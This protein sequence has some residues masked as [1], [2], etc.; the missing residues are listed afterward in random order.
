[1]RPQLA[2]ALLLGGAFAF[3][4]TRA[5]IG[6]PDAFWHIAA[7]RDMLARGVLRADAS[8]WTAAGVPVAVDQWLGQLALWAAYALG[9]WRGVVA[10]RAL[11]AGLLVGLVAFAA[12]DARPSRPLVAV[13]AAL[14]AA[15][16]SQ[17]VASERPELFG[18]ACFALLMVLLRRGRDGGARALAACVPLL[19]LWA[20]VHGSFALGV[21]L[22]VLVC[23]EGAAAEPAHRRRYALVAAAALAASLLTP[24]GIGVWAAPGLHFT[25]PPRFIAEWAVPD[26][27]SPHGAIF[28]LTLAAVS[29]AAFLDR[30][31]GG[32]REAVL[33]VP[34]LFLALTAQRQLAFFAIAAAPYLAARVPA[35]P[36]ERFSAPRGILPASAAL[37]LAALV[38][39]I[40]TGPSRPAPSPAAAL[41][42]ALPPG[43]GLFN[44]YDW[45]G[46][47]VFD[48]PSS[49]VF[50]DGRLVPYLGAVV[51]DYVRIR[52][53]QPGWREVVRRRGIR[54]LLVRADAPVAVRALELGWRTRA[55]APGAVVVD[56]P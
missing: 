33:L 36:L 10:L 7:G 46:Y 24:A 16:L 4:S 26:V 39:G 14:P 28:A 55:A 44:E 50:I 1:M 56:V 32:R 45:G 17:A 23:L 54:T 43:P 47:L 5:P 18:L 25:N 22:T 41:A 34:V 49:P 11:A 37:A 35:A 27:R 20:N 19:V 2:V 51:D 21:A 29:C 52:A 8:S 12:S 30:T 3:V 53:A 31:P 15:L 38:L 40:A 42:A 13:V 9:D 48:H 6:D